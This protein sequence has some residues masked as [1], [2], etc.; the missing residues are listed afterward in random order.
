MPLE[1][2]TGPG[3]YIDTFNVNWPVGA[4]DDISEGD[5]HIRGVKNCIS[6]TFP[7][8][9]AAVNPTPAELNHCVGVSSPI[10]TQLD[11]KSS[12]GHTH[13]T[14]YSPIGHTHTEYA[15]VSHNHDD[16][17]SP[18]GH[19]HPDYEQRL[20]DLENAP[21]GSEPDPS[22]VVSN[23]GVD[24]KVTI[25]KASPTEVVG[26]TLLFAPPG[27]LV[28]VSVNG[29]APQSHGYVNAQGHYMHLEDSQDFIGLPN[30]NYVYELF[31]GGS[32][33]ATYTLVL[34]S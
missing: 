27:A 10:Q 11:N 21:G 14:L 24:G 34:M 17:Y 30:G 20:T 22:V 7:N 23:V 2:M 8:I 12:L 31:V 16:L 4:D 28:E 32:L 29:E 6:N 9:D 19:T 25:S 26:Y 3:V 33:F 13:D 1:D 5:D 18:L 15:P